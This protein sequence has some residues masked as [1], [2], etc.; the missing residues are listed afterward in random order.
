LGETTAG[1]FSNDD[2]LAGRILRSAQRTGD[3]CWRMPLDPTQRNKLKTDVADLVN[4]HEGF[5]GAVT[6]ALFLE[7]FAGGVPWAHFDIYAWTGGS[8]AFS[9]KGGSGQVVQCLANLCQEL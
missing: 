2:K 3:N 1:L 5:G 4:A 9:E 6:A 8:G 7:N